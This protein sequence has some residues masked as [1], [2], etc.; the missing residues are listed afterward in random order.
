MGLHKMYTFLPSKDQRRS[1]S[2][3]RKKVGYSIF[4]FSQVFQLLLSGFG[5][6]AI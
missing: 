1:G 6:K 5:L 3:C 4:K 2:R